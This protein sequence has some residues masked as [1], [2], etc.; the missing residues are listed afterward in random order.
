MFPDIY[1]LFV[2]LLFRLACLKALSGPLREIYFLT[3]RFSATIAVSGKIFIFYRYGHLFPVAWS[4]APLPGAF[5][6]I[7]T[8]D[9]IFEILLDAR[10]GGPDD[11]PGNWKSNC[12]GWA[13]GFLPDLL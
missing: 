4:F 13:P 9:E 12:P 8:S 10:A 7:P 11:L 6:L 2:Y 5:T 3:S 1:S